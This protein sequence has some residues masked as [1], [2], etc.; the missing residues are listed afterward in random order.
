MNWYLGSYMHLSF[1]IIDI[2]HEI[3]GVVKGFMGENWL[4]E[5][6]FKRLL[7]EEDYI[8][9]KGF[10]SKFNEFERREIYRIVTKY[11]EWLDNANKFDD[12][13][14]AYQM[15]LMYEEG[16]Q[17]KIPILVIDEVQDFTERQIVMM[18][19]ITFDYHIYLCGDPN[20]I[21]NPTLFSFGR[22]S[23][24]FYNRQSKSPRMISLKNNYRNSAPVVEIINNITMKRK[25][26]IGFQ[27]RE[28]D[29]LE[30]PMRTDTFG[31]RLLNVHPTEEN[32]K[33]VVSLFEKTPSA[34]IIVT[35]DDEREVLEKKINSKLNS[36]F[37]IFEVKG[38]EFN[39]VFCYNIFSGYKDIWN[40]IM[41]G[42]GKRSSAHRFHFNVLYVAIT[43]SKEYISFFEDSKNTFLINDLDVRYIEKV[44]EDSMEINSLRDPFEWYEDGVMFEKAGLYNKAILAYE[45]HYDFSGINMKKDI[46]RCE[47]NI[48]LETNKTF[49]GFF[50]AG[51]LLI[52]A[53]DYLGAER[54]F[55]DIDVKYKIH[56]CQIRRGMYKHRSHLSKE[57][58][59][60]ILLQ[61][62]DDEVFF[63][64]FIEAYLIPKSRDLVTNSEMIKGILLPELLEVML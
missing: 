1:K 38:L 11:N 4:Q 48:I 34:A 26:L 33:E 52:E 59:N 14:L 12:N 24:F 46:S 63:K 36:V 43:R 10:D 51:N 39:H 31:T 41:N 18:S 53:E 6:S 62:M 44:D 58:M 42:H 32:L 28:D 35:T 8:G 50:K 7:D 15:F 2:W 57:E 29:A 13:D 21:I 55:S 25:T 23:N 47:A 20:Q 45:K 30:R 64:L 22:V 3:R 17:D 5:A 49:E 37:T 16:K 56:E 54:I 40:E 61:G 27:K 19:Y 9:K 60:S